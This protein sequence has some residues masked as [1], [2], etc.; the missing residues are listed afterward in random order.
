MI[1]LALLSL[2]AAGSAQNLLSYEWKFKTGDDMAWAAM[3]QD[4]SEWGMIEAGTA[5]ENQGYGDYDG[6][7]WYRQKVVVPSDLKTMAEENGGLV[8]KIG[9]VDDCDMAYFNGALIGSAGE[10]PPEYKTGYGIKREYK[11]AASAIKWDEVNLVALRIYDGG[12]GG[13]IDQE[14]TSLSV[15]GAEEL[16]SLEALTGSDDHI[17]LEEGELELNL[18]LGNQMNK[19]LSGTI[20]LTGKSDFGEP[21]L[22]KTIKVKVSQGREKKLKVRLGELAPGF[23]H[24]AA[25]LNSNLTS[26]R[27]SFHIG[28]R[29]GEIVSPLDRPE[30]FDDF[31]TRARRELDAVAPQFKLTLHE[32]LSTETRDVYLVEMRSLGNIIVRGWYGR[33]KKEG[34]Y[35][36]TLKVQGYSSV[37]QPAYLYKGDDMVDLVLNIR[38]HGN[39]RDVVNPGFP[40]Y[41][42]HHVDDPELYIYRGAFMDCIRAV[43]FLY[44]REEVDKGRVAVQ[45]GSQGGA[46]SFATAAL[47]PERIALCVPGVPFLSDYPDYFKLV[48]WPGGEFVNYLR[49]HPEISRDELYRNLSYFDIKN[50]APWIKAPMYM[51][52]GLKD[53]TCPPHI[54]FAAYNQVQGEKTYVA[55]PEAGHGLPA[56]HS[57]AWL[58]WVKQH[59]GMEE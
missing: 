58:R 49:E 5:W 33:P 16:I 11:I 46:L 36:A 12:G 17:Y 54:N 2:F 40:G 31:W 37:M 3:A 42:Q 53:G 10:F 52:I 39:S 24:F 4:D 50:L 38:G 22:E 34:V 43:D 21:I 35:P 6:Y 57:A 23:Y 29:P 56:E 26:K 59:F 25:M 32:E 45:G 1:V 19:T 55:Y 13:G 27:M 48:G 51:A 30:D 28:V 47:D 44:S 7:A 9:N 14:P 18:V 20:E 15:I 8:L 41:L